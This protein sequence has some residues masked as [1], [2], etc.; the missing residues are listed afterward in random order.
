MILDI[1]PICKQYKQ[2]GYVNKKI[3]QNDEKLQHAVL[4]IYDSRIL[5]ISLTKNKKEKEYYKIIQLNKTEE[6]MQKQIQNNIRRGKMHNMNVQKNKFNNF[7]Y[8]TMI[9]SIEQFSKPP[10]TQREIISIINQNRNKYNPI[11][12][13]NNCNQIATV[14]NQLL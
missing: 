14:W 4:N 5:I 13:T 2:N 8:Q 6:S 3:T 9:L 11:K 10:Y 7:E 12:T 1:T